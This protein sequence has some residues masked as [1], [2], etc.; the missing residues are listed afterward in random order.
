MKWIAADFAKVDENKLPIG[1]PT[2]E[3]SYGDIDAGFSKAKLVIDESF[4][5]E[6]NSHHSMEPRTAMAY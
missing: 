6:V 1:K 2:T 4:V 3:W 5:V